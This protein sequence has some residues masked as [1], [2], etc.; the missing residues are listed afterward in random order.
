MGIY[1]LAILNPALKSLSY[2]SLELCFRTH[3]IFDIYF[4]CYFDRNE[5]KIDFWGNVGFIS[6]KI[7]KLIIT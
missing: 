6:I 1:D 5:I 2:L 4:N 7:I 3:P